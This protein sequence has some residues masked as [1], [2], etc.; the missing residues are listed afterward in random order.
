M[1]FRGGDVP[2]LLHVLLVHEASNSSFF[3]FGASG[4]EFVFFAVLEHQASSSYFFRFVCAFGVF[5]VVRLV[6]N[7]LLGIE[8]VFFAL[9]WFSQKVPR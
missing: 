6:S 5:F 4:I 9:W 3:T 2:V 8:F 1:G 7:S